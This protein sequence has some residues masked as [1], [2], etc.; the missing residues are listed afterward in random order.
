MT[1]TET[2]ELLEAYK[3]AKTAWNYAYERA[4]TDT[5]MWQQAQKLFDAV[6]FFERRLYD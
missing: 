4:H 5:H 1:A 2:K 6:C 3:A